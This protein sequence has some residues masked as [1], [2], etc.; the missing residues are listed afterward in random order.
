MHARIKENLNRIRDRIAAAASRAGRDP[1][2]VRIVAV[3]K[4]VGLAEVEILREL[5]VS[6]MGENRIEVARPKIENGPK[7][8]RWHMIAPLQTRKAREVAELFACF[9]AVDR[10]KAAEAL[11]MR[12]DET[13]RGMPVLV[14][15]NVT[16]E[17][18]KHGFSPPDLGRV[19]D[20][21]RAFP[22][23]RVEGLM[24][25]AP[26]DAPESVVRPCF[27]RLKSLADAHGLPEVSMGMTD[28]FEIAVEEGSTQI[29]VGRALFE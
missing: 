24:T 7:D 25:M 21:L 16:G 14:E 8:I 15:V 3:T 29:R 5:G 18:S 6:D 11:D 28:D 13:G 2:G 1:A 17:E 20:A 9:D 26:F 4:T 27:S 19:L 10:V 12:C 23:L 22:R